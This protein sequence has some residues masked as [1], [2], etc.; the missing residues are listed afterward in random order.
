MPFRDRLK[1]AFN[2]FTG[3]SDPPPDVGYATATAQYE[4]A[5][6]YRTRFGI[7]NDKSIISSIYTRMSIDVASFPF[8]HILLDEKGRYKDDAPSVLN[9]CLSQE[10][11]LDQAPSAFVQDIAMTLFVNGCAALVPIDTT[12][13]DDGQLIDIYSVRVGEIVGWHPNHVRVRVYNE[14]LGIRQEITLEKQSVAIVQNPLHTV[15]NAPSSTMQRLVKK[16]TILDVIDEQSGSGKLDI[17]IQLPYITRGETR[18][19]QAEARRTE[20][21][22][23]LK[24]S[25][26]GVAYA[27]ASEK[28]TQLNRPAENNMMAQIEYLIEQLYGEL[29]ITKEVM[30]GT[31][32]EKTMINYFNR[33]V[34]PILRAVKEAMQRSFLGTKAFTKKE[35]IAFFKDPFKLLALSDLAEITD[36]MARNEVLTSNEI[37]GAIGFMPSD[38]P[39][40]DQLVNAN[41]PQKSDE[42]SNGDQPSDTPLDEPAA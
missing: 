5:S 9:T 11:N 34:E 33:T 29:G 7:L 21:E 8:R 10:T 12:R 26:Y 14:K 41:M 30:N 31:A 20:M 28:I 36:K 6:S 38:D 19:N 13:D 39:K 32:D 3:G 24:D 22:L 15:M 40:A 27:D 35:A 4:G 23:Q 16:L 2:A 1:R 17:I 25:Q 37:R 18:K 42:S